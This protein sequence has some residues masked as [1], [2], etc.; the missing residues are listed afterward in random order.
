MSLY[1]DE[2]PHGTLPKE[3]PAVIEFGREEEL[4]KGEEQMLNTLAGN[5]A[6]IIQADFNNINDRVNGLEKGFEQITLA[7]NQLI[8]ANNK[9]TTAFNNQGQAAISTTATGQATT[10]IDKLEGLSKLMEHAGPLLDRIFPQS[11][12][13]PS[14]IDP[15]YI[16]E[17]V[18]QSI[19]SNFEIGEAIQQNLKSKLMQKTMTRVLSDAITHVPDVA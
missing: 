3:K 15:N 9:L 4:R 8:E 10:G 7:L 6:K 18:K 5:V 1:P 16:N 19:M 12:A 13:P 14:I 2:R 17:K 11:S